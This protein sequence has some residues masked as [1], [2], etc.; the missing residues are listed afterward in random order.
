MSKPIAPQRQWKINIT[1]S[2]IEHRHKKEMGIFSFLRCYLLARI[3]YHMC[4]ASRWMSNTHIIL[5]LVCFFQQN[6]RIPKLPFISWLWGCLHFNSSMFKLPTICHVICNF[7]YK[8]RSPP[9][10][11]WRR[12]MHIAWLHYTHFAMWMHMERSSRV[13]G[14]AP[15][16]IYKYNA[17]WMA[18]RQVD[19]EIESEPA[20]RRAECIDASRSPQFQFYE[21]SNGNDG[22]VK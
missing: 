5:T 21:I 3:A 9:S 22:N 7:N 18:G 4:V 13:H 16:A 19:Q 17:L 14:C 2:S 20:H 10:S 6:S 1:N 15:V 11:V 12:R 8:I